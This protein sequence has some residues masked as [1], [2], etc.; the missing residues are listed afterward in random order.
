MTLTIEGESDGGSRH[1]A[2]PIV[3]VRHFPRLAAGRH[4]DPQVHELVRAVS[5]DR[6]SSPVMTGPAT[7][8]L[9]AAPGEEHDTLAPVRIDRGYRFTFG[10][11]VDDLETVKELVT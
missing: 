9:H 8:R 7:L 1:N 10:Y 11:T 2:P 5:R 4:E 6:A 3:N